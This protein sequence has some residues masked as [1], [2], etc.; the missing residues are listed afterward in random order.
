[1]EK[2]PFSKL[3]NLEGKFCP[4]P[5]AEYLPVAISLR[6]YFNLVL[7]GAPLSRFHPDASCLITLD[8]LEGWRVEWTILRFDLWFQSSR[9]WW[10]AF[11]NSQQFLS[12]NW[13]GR[14]EES[15]SKLPQF[16]YFSAALFKIIAFSNLVWADGLKVFQYRL[17]FTS[18]YKQGAALV[19]VTIH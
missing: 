8:T 14:R 15:L 17:K 1:M 16:C 10:S 13:A 18:K 3:W 12:V 4:G 2:R 5:P 19:N 9:C 6:R 11:Q 7:A